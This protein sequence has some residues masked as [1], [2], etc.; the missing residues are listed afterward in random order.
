[1][2]PPI[3]L[4]RWCSG[5]E[6]ACRCRR[7]L[8]FDPWVRKISWRRKWQPTPGF[9]PEKSQRQKSL[10]GYSPWGLKESDTTKHTR[11]HQLAFFYLVLFAL[12][13][14]KSSGIFGIQTMPESPLLSSV[15]HVIPPFI[16]NSLGTANFLRDTLLYIC[17]DFSHCLVHTG[18]SLNIWE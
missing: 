13:Y 11:I 10:E 7:C 18:H 12:S 9:L 16:T 1:M 4:P 6:S 2:L 5:G 15:F 17:V 8:R 3:G 14:S